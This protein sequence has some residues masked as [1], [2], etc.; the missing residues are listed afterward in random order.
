MTNSFLNNQE[1]NGNNTLLDL[2]NTT[3]KRVLLKNNSNNF[4]NI[5]KISNNT[6]S[7]YL[8]NNNNISC[9]NIS[10]CK[11]NND[12]YT[13]KITTT[14]QKTFRKSASQKLR[15]NKIN[16]NEN[17]YSKTLEVK[18]NSKFLFKI[19]FQNDNIA[20]L[21]FDIINHEF[22]IINFINCDNFELDFKEKGVNVLSA[23]N[24]KG[25]TTI[26]SHIV[27][28]FYELARKNYNNEFKGIDD[29]FYR[30]SSP[31]DP[32]K[33]GEPSLVFLRFR[34]NS[35]VWDY[36]DVRNKCTKEQ[37]ELFYKDTIITFEEIQESINKER[38]LKK[39]SNNVNKDLV[40]QTFNENLLTYFPAYRYEEPCYLND[41][42]KFRLSFKKDL[43]MNGYLTNPI[44]VVSD[45]KDLSNW[46]MDIVLDYQIYKD[47]N[48]LELRNSFN[49]ILSNALSGK[50]VGNCRIG[51]GPRNSSGIRISVVKD[52]PN[53]I[54]EVIYPSLFSISSGE[55][56][57]L[58][59]FGELLHQADKLGQLLLVSG[60]V[61]ID[62]VDKHLHITLQKEIL[63]KLFS[64][65]PNLQFIVSSHSPFLNMGLADEAKER[66]Q[67]I[68]LDNNGFVCEPTNNDLYKDVYEMMINE[69]N[70]FYNHYINLQRELEE[71]S[72]PIVITEGKTDIVYI[73]KAKEKL[74]VTID[75]NTINPLHQPNGDP[76]LQ[77]L[78]K[79]LCL[80]K[81]NNKIIAVF[82]RD[83][84]N[85]V[86][87]MDDYGVGYKSYGNNVYGFCISAP[88]SRIDKGQNHISIEYL[89]SDD[90]IHTRLP[91]DCQLFFGD[92]FLETSGRHTINKELVLKNQDDRG[93][94]KIVE[95]N[96][97]QAVF[98]LNE[99]NI[100]AKKSD[101]AN[102]IDKDQI[103]I[104]QESWNNFRHIFDKIDTIINL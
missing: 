97:G 51:I 59:L 71:I 64:L 78:L 44:E 2:T 14:M 41:P 82:D 61:L 62:E 102:A 6:N 77:K 104:S 95:N 31:L 19:I 17:I 63:P 50:I 93:K 42:Y 36:I 79:K 11:L 5:S 21:G 75:F 48:S 87:T 32:L 55:A 67:I 99:N 16:N 86:Q 46:L 33:P 47:S 4:N 100:L 85:T 25:K 28:A 40:I 54:V 74:G 26:L 80:V 10:K 70:R 38:F 9:S 1:Y 72:K 30:Y 18:R 73:L 20:L 90:E 69:N 12:I 101:F 83:I 103:E 98:D 29:Q 23:I 13:K 94:H 35:M 68:D 91:N 57:M 27:D 45:L 66:S 37:F 53:S 24:G 52:K 60:I 65:F 92:E 34:N 8:T 84:P 89:F 7:N 96:G 49:K 22:N 43:D 56:A 58:C 15:V 88:Q 39:W 3:Y 81:H 76:D